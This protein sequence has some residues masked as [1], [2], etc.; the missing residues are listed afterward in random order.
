MTDGSQDIGPRAVIIIRHAEK[1][2]ELSDPDLSEIGKRRSMVLAAALPAAFGRI[3]AIIAA[4]SSERSVRPFRT[5]QPLAFA[6]GIH[7]WQ[8]WDTDYVDEL[9]DTLIHGGAFDGKQVLICWR[10]RTL[11]H[12]AMALGARPTH[13]WPEADYEHMIVVCRRPGMRVRWYRQVL[14]GKELVITPS[15]DP[16]GENLD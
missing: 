12:L 14:D 6:Q 4:R 2:G 3:D 11:H 8:N 9:V 7:V 5:V 16:S 10:H 1:T 13:P 15:E